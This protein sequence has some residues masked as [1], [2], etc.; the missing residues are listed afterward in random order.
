MRGRMKNFCA[1]LAG[2]SAVRAHATKGK[3]P[4]D[5]FSVSHNTHVI[6]QVGWVVGHSYITYGPLIQG[7]TTMLYEGKPI[8]TPDA[9]EWWRV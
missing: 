7:C 4:A 2:R 6:A 9:G 1:I 3:N 5:D 8:G